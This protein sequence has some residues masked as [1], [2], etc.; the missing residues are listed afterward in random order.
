MDYMNI[1]N[2][3]NYWSWCVCAW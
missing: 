1:E 3:A 2:T